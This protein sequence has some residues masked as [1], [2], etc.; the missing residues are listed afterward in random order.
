MK[1]LNYI[2]ITVFTLLF[3]QRT[4]SENISFVNSTP[5]CTIE[6]LNDNNGQNSHGG[7]LQKLILLHWTVMELTL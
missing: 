5:D 1:N 6:K 2:L 4:I 7:F 3:S